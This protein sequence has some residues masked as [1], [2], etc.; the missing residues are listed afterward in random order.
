MVH[1][2]DVASEVQ[3]DREL[4][5]GED[6]RRRG[7]GGTGMNVEEMLACWRVSGKLMLSFSEW[8]TERCGLGVL[9]FPETVASAVRRWR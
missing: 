5:V 7:K 6:G 1:E 3:S 2:S 9:C 8:K 4:V